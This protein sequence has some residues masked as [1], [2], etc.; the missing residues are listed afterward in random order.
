MDTW[1]VEKVSEARQR[2]AQLRE[3]ASQTETADVKKQL[4]EVSASWD[5]LAALIEAYAHRPK[6]ILSKI[7]AQEDHPAH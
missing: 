6:K 4:L 7:A 5:E 1:M 2:A 3:H